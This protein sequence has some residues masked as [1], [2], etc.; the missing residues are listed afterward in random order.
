MR[1]PIKRCLKG[2][3]NA[4]QTFF[5][6]WLS[7]DLQVRKNYELFAAKVTGNGLVDMAADPWHDAQLPGLRFVWGGMGCGEGRWETW[8]GRLPFDGMTKA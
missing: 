1:G 5:V 2:P 3:C 6:V 8:N 4:S 7:S